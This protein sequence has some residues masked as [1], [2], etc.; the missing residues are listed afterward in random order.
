[1]VV[2]GYRRYAGVDDFAVVRLHGED[3]LLDAS[4]DGE[5]W[6][7]T[8]LTA[9]DDHGTDVVVQPDGKILVAGDIAVGGDKDIG[10]VRYNADGSLDTILD[11]D[12]I[13]STPIPDT[14]RGTRSVA[15]LPDGRFLVAGHVQGFGVE[16]WTLGRYLPNGALDSSY[17]TGGVAV[18]DLEEM[19]DSMG[20]MVLDPAGNAVIAGTSAG[21]PVVARIL[22]GGTATGVGDPGEGDPGFPAFLLAPPHPNPT[23]RGAFLHFRLL[24]PGRVTAEVLDVGG[25]LVRTLADRA[26]RD[27]G[28]HSLYWD[29]LSASGRPVAGG[30]YFIR[31]SEG[32][33]SEVRKITVLP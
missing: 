33:F 27:A 2:A 6:A 14:Y 3:G 15:L 31:V 7:I 21:R 11:G 16:D 30:V 23:A 9:G 4:F 29:G 22:G 18:L 12:G 28:P 24:E 13:A 20:G 5:G 8:S 1:V 25:R 19:S 32:S 26:P 17:G 10:L